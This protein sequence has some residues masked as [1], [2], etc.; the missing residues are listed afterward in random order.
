MALPRSSKKNVRP[1]ARSRAWCRVMVDF[2]K[3]DFVGGVAA[4]AQR[5]AFEHEAF[6]RREESIRLVLTRRARARPGR[7][8]A[9]A[10]TSRIHVR[11]SPAPGND[12]EYQFQSGISSRRHCCTR[13]SRKGA[14]LVQDT[15]SVVFAS[16]LPLL[17][18]ILPALAALA[19][20]VR[21]CATR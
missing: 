7:R 18:L 13:A 4:D 14:T 2:G 12:A 8:S 6:G 10:A 9:C 11:Q 19:A 20:L 1:S 3:H 16:S 5:L 17:L 21:G 15:R